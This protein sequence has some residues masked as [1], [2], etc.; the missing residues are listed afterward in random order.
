MSL[1]GKGAIV[2]GSSRGIGK[3][4]AL[5]LAREGCSIVVAVRS[6]TERPGLPGTIHA[7]ANE[8]QALCGK[9]LAPCGARAD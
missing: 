1:S 3:A 6:E 7:T 4:I 2:T 9:A 5:G 8:V